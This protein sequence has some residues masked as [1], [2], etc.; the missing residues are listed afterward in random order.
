VFQGAA[1]RPDA[2]FNAINVLESGGNSSYNGIDVTLRRRLTAGLQF[3]ATWTWSHALGDADMQGGALSN[4]FQR[5]FD[6]GALNG[7]ARHSLNFAILY[8]PSTRIR[9][10][11]FVNGWEVAPMGFW[12]TGYPIDP[13]A[14]VDLNSDLVLNDRNVGVAKNSVDGPGFLQFDVRLLRRIRW[15]DTQSLELMV[16][17]DNV[18]NTLNA[19][20]ANACTGAVVNREAAVDFGRITSAR[21]ARRVQFGLRYSF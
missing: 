7:D 2:R 5:T 4:P 11:R 17:S 6:Y 3:T 13:R 20:C 8:A 14:G 18:F 1:G 15:M 21:T 12:N 9:L 16:E 19:N 10:L